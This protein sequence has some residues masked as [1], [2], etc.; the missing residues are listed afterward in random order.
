MSDLV[1]A[2]LSIERDLMERFDRL[3]DESGHHNRSEAIRELIRARLL[4]QDEGARGE[5]V[6]SVMLLYDHSKRR[7]SRRIEEHGHAHH[8]VVLSSLHVHISPEICLEV[9][10][11]RGPMEELRHV[12]NHLTG[13]PGVLH[14]RAVFSR[15]DPSE[16]LG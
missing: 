5:S 15:A 8:D 9:V 4:E 3:V 11:L 13:L 2:S 16:E 12:A 7:V 14:G 1:R 10:L 6:A